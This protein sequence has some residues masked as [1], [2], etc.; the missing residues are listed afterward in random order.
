MVPVLLVK[1]CNN[2]QSEKN[3]RSLTLNFFC[4]KLERGDRKGRKKRYK[5]PLIFT[6]AGIFS[7]ATKKMPSKL[8]HPR[9]QK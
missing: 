8:H 4:K 6:K 2:S 5:C 3:D 7:L 9:M 1:D